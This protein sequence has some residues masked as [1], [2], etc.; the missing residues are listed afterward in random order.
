[1]SHKN[2]TS[3]NTIQCNI[4]FMLLRKLYSM[5]FESWGPQS[6][7]NPALFINDSDHI[8]ARTFTE[9]SSSQVSGFDFKCFKFVALVHYL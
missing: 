3:L 4:D 5:R 1:M 9:H 7:A 8:F 6:N 2:S